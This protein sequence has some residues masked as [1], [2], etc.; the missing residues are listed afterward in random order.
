MPKRKLIG[1][2]TQILTMGNLPAKGPL[3]DHQLE[4][5]EE[6][7]VLVEGGLIIEIGY[8][9]ALADKYAHEKPELQEIT[10]DFI[11]LPGFIDAHTHMCFA[12]SRAADY[13]LKVAGSQYQEILKAGGGIHH[14][15]AQTRAATAAQLQTLLL[16]RCNRHLQDG[17]TTAEVKSGY[18]L[19][20]AEEL[21]MLEA[22][23]Q[24]HQNHAIDL[25]PTCLA[26]HV[27]PKEYASEEH[28]LHDITS[29]LFPLMKSR[30]LSQRVDI[31]VEAGA[32]APALARA[33]LQKAKAA[34]FYLTIHADQFTTGGSAL[35]VEMGACSADHLEASGTDEIAALAKSNVVAVALPGASLGLG[36][37][38]TPARKL[39]DAGAILAIASD[40]NPGSAPMG[41]LLLQ[42]A[43]IGAAEKLSMAETLAAITCRAAMALALTDRGTLSPGM[44]A[45]LIA[46]QTS[47]FREILYHQG[48]LKPDMVWKKGN[49]VI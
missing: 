48:K 30:E 17:V 41:D 33:Y 18:G 3:K 36:M 32:F 28:Y 19:S 49:Q 1:P 4:I 13:A 24:V 31:F 16:S 40:W 45:D 12:G 34:G 43:V 47:D 29:D 6:G 11:L 35:A 8:Y 25:I 26:A 21:K 10:G 46:F 38:F 23:H 2:F 7:G 9:H 5:F 39:L 20:I 22:I 27:K 44:L 15:V 42:A 37:P 14:T